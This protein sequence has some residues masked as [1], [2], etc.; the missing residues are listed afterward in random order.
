MNCKNKNYLLKLCFGFVLLVMFLSA[1]SNN[2]NNKSEDVGNITYS[3]V[4][5]F[6]RISDLFGEGW[7]INGNLAVTEDENNNYYFDNNIPENLR[8]TYINNQKK[9]FSVLTENGVE[10]EQSNI[11]VLSGIQDRSVKSDNSMYIDVSSSGNISQINATLQLVLGEYTNYGYIYSLSNYIAEKFNWN[12]D[13]SATLNESVFHENKNLLNLVYPCYSNKYAN[14]E[15]IS[16]CQALANEILSCMS[17]PFAGQEEFKRQLDEYILKENFE[18]DRTNLVFAFGGDNCPLKIRTDYLEVYLNS[19]YRGSCLLTEKSLNDDPMFNFQNLID[20]WEYVDS[21]LSEVRK[22]FGFNDSNVISVYVQEL[23]IGIAQNG[24][25]GGYFH[26]TVDGPQILMEDIYSITHEYTHYIDFCMDKNLNDDID[27]CSEVLACFYGK[28]M[29]YVERI[30]KA[31]SG[32][33]NVWTIELLSNLIGSVYDSV[34][35]E[36]MFMNIMNAYEEK[37]KYALMTLYNGRL[38]FGCY[39]VDTYGEDAFIECML[40]PNSSNSIIGCSIDKVVNDWC[41]WLEQFK[42]LG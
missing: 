6:V 3:Y 41:I 13:K 5:E 11:Y 8:A 42:I 19:D 17:N 30:V 7:L 23:N 15:Q 1:C 35:D 14:Q 40:S 18:C 2:T 29:S 4:Q 31:N 16:A 33:P 22:Q 12:V 26:V 28:N 27:W 36:I 21:D 25:A 10:V 24:E 34:D 37:P 32:D 9:I 38:S 39:F 20:F